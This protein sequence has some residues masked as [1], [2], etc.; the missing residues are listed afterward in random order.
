MIYYIAS[1]LLS[2]PLYCDSL[3]DNDICDG[4][5]IP[6][7]SPTSIYSE[8]HGRLGNHLLTYCLLYQLKTTLRINAYIA[9][10]TH[11]ILGRIFTKDSIRLP[12]LSDRCGDVGEVRKTWELYNRHL[13][14]LLVD[15][16]YRTGRAL[17]LFPGRMVGDE[18]E[19]SGYQ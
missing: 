18:G 16:S 19:F 12:K 3:K 10:G 7:D 9:D 15:K 13:R 11:D 8:A 14:Q 17:Y 6:P 1:S 5:Q 2:L 4:R